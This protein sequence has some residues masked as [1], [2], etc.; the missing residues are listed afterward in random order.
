MGMPFASGHYLALRDMVATS[1]GPGVPGHLAPR[2]AGTLDH[3]HDRTRRADLSAV[4]RVGGRDRPGTPSID[5]SW[6]DDHT[7]EVT[8][9]DELRWRIELG[10]TPATR[11]MTAMGG[12]LPEAGWNSNA[13]LAA[14]G[15]MAANH[16]PDRT[17]SDC[18]ARRRTARGSGRR[19]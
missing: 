8:L 2:P 4:L 9:G 6:R 5:V 18:T 16:A 7:L 19:P 14:M 3:P 13:V 17:G 12:A 10:A 15:P 11:M 1:V